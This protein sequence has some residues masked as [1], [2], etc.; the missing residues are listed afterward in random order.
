MCGNSAGPFDGALP[1]AI[2]PAAPNVGTTMV[3]SDSV[4]PAWTGSVSNVGKP[5]TGGGTHKVLA[6]WN[7]TA[8]CIAG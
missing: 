7:G 8:W 6:R 2:F 5:I 3:C 1:L 4:D